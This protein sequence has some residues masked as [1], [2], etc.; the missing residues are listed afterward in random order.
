[1]NSDCAL[2]RLA[3]TR[4]IYLHTRLYQ[5]AYPSML[6]EGVGVEPTHTVSSVLR[7]KNLLYVSMVG[8]TGVEPAIVGYKPSATKPFHLCPYIMGKI[9]IRWYEL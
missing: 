9:P 7:R 2:A 6:V 8:T 3:Y 1:M 5:F 4:Y